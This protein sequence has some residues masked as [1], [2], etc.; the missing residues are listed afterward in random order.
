[1]AATDLYVSRVRAMSTLLEGLDKAVWLRNAA[2]YEWTVH[3]LIAHL[4]VIEHYTAA[5]LGLVSAQIDASTDDHLAMGAELIATELRDSPVATIQRWAAAADRVVQ[6][7]RSADFRTDKAVTL[8]GWPFSASA[9]LV[10][11]A[12]ELWTHTDD[13]RRAA[14]LPFEQTDA[15]ELRTMSSYS[16][17]SLPFL[18]PTVASERAL[19]PTRVVLTGAGGGTYDIGGAGERKA[20]L[21]AD[22]VEYCQVVARRVEPRDLFATIEGDEALVRALLDASRAFAV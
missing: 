14:G 13:V 16:V 2:P 22:V 18:L 1:M 21:V 10:A 15:A 4:L 17:A 20:L 6:H 5:Q 9:A 12:F 3:G 11:R 7:V 8:H 19:T